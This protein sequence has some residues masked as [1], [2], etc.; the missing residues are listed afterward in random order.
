MTRLYPWHKLPKF[1]ELDIPPT[2]R[3]KKREKTDPGTEDQLYL[4]QSR[5][6]WSDH[7]WP[8]SRADCCSVR[9][10]LPLHIHPWNSPFKVPAPWSV[11][12]HRNWL[13]DTN[14]PSSQVASLLHKAT[15][16]FR[17]L[18]ISLVLACEQ[19]AAKPEFSNNFTTRFSLIER[20]WQLQV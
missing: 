20:Q 12:P 10:P 1:W 16:S 2:P 14:A 5:W 15:L 17:P 8:I 4:K 19:L 6:C 7:W 11:N 18:L 13:L 9:S 3:P